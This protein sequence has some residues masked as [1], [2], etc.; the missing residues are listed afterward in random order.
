MESKV[1]KKAVFHGIRATLCGKYRVEHR[2]G[3]RYSIYKA[4]KEG[5]AFLHDGIVNARSYE[6]ALETYKNRI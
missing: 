2:G 4:N 3:R 5:S 1:F 6:Q